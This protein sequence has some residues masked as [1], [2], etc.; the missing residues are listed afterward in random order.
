MFVITV[1]RNNREE[2]TAAKCNNTQLILNE[3]TIVLINV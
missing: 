1:I 3:S 2:K